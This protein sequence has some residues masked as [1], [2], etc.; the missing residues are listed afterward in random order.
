MSKI[1]NYIDFLYLKEEMIH[2][3]ELSGLVKSITPQN[4]TKS[5]IQNI[6]NS[7]DEKDIEGSIKKVKRVLMPMPKIKLS[8]ID[9]FMNSKYKDYFKLKRTANVI[10]NNS[11]PG[12]SKNMLD[13]A[14][15]FIVISSMVAK[16]SE[17]N[18]DPKE[19]MKRNIKDFVVKVRSFYDDDEE[20]VKGDNSPDSKVNKDMLV[21]YA[22]IAIGIVLAVGVA[23]SMLVIVSAVFSFWTLLIVGTFIV[24][25]RLAIE[26]MKTG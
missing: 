18:K 16:K 13:V 3:E 8:K 14:S 23:K 4:K 15:S 24:I 1:D 10:L 6:S 21:G 19:L 17:S 11:I 22:T 25:W 2:E 5:M 20:E 7:L 12:V 26:G 9:N